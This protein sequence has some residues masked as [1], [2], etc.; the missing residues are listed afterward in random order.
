MNLED[1]DYTFTDEQV[2]ALGFTSY[3]ELEKYY[4]I[5]YDFMDMPYDKNKCVD[6]LERMGLD[7]RL[8]DSREEKFI[9]SMYDII[10]VMEDMSQDGPVDDADFLNLSNALNKRVAIFNQ[11][12]NKKFNIKTNKSHTHR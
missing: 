6:Q 2:K 8:D 1:R 5:L 7:I 10:G 9:K 11:M 4:D 12:M 3:E